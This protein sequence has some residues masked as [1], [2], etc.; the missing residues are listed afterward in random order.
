MADPKLTVALNLKKKK[1][2]LGF[3]FLYFIGIIYVSKIVH[4]VLAL[5]K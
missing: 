4:H 2:H 1:N 3:F 5:F